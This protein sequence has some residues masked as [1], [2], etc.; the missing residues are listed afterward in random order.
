[1]IRS[2]CVAD[3]W[4]CMCEGTRRNRRFKYNGSVMYYVKLTMCTFEIRVIILCSN[5]S[6]SGIFMGFLKRG[7]ILKNWEGV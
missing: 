1:V 3:L 2:T 7:C 5:V 6:R 4:V